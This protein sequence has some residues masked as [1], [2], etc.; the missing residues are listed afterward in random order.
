MLLC[1]RPALSDVLTHAVSEAN[2]MF[3][4]ALGCVFDLA[5]DFLPACDLLVQPGSGPNH[6]IISNNSSRALTSNPG[7]DVKSQE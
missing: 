5:Q 7:Q 1:Q 3:A 2:G 4:S 6:D